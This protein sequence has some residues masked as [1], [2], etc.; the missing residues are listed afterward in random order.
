MHTDA[1]YPRPGGPSGDDWIDAREERGWLESPAAQPAWYRSGVAHLVGI[2]LFEDD[3]RRR[4]AALEKLR[5]AVA[6]LGRTE[7]D[8]R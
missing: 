2:V 6:A 8:K 4:E 1:I 7:R 5:R 3:D